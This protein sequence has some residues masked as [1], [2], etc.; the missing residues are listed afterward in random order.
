MAGAT[1]ILLA[2]TGTVGLVCLLIGLRKRLD[3]KTRTTVS[4]VAFLFWIVFTF[5]SY[6]VFIGSSSDR[7]RFTMFAFMG[8]FL[9]LV[10]FVVLSYNGF[11]VFD[12]AT[13]KTRRTTP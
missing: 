7:E 13:D 3:A 8:L 9:T 4:G 2:W 10:S 11:Q 5:G 12:E 6:G 1:P